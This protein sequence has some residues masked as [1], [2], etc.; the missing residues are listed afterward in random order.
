MPL[1]AADD[2]RIPPNGVGFVAPEAIAVQIENI[3]T[4]GTKATDRG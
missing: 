2:A 3:T 4:P 1:R